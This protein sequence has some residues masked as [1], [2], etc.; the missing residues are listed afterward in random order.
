MASASSAPA[1][2]DDEKETREAEALLLAM[3]QYHPI[4]S[5]QPRRARLCT[6]A[7]TRFSSAAPLDVLLFFSKLPGA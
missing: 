6:D 4:V 2:G 7:H 5:S 3:E 1:L